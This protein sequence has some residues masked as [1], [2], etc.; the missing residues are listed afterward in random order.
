MFLIK[1]ALVEEIHRAEKLL[2]DNKVIDARSPIEA[3]RKI[4]K[5]VKRVRN[6]SIVVN[7]K[8][9]YEGEIKK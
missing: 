3:V 7:H 5:N 1:M 9:C 2:D 8:Y 6:G 4:Y